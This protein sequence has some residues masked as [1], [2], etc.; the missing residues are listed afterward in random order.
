MSHMSK[1][2][3]SVELAKHVLLSV[4][5]ATVLLW[6]VKIGAEMGIVDE[7]MKNMSMLAGYALFGYALLP[8]VRT[9]RPAL[10]TVKEMYTERTA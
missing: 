4:V 9:I 2:Y 5:L 7:E 10:G 1:E 8:G 6:Q 3:S